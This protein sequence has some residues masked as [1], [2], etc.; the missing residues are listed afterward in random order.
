MLLLV[1]SISKADDYVWGEEFIEGDVISATTFN[2]IFN[3]L[4]KLNRTPVDADLVGT[5]SCS[6]LHTDF[7]SS[8]TTGWTTNNFVYTLTGAQ[9]TMTASTDSTSLVQPYSYS[10]SAPNPFYRH[11]TG[12]PSASGSY[13]LYEGILL[14]RMTVGIS[15]ST[16]EWKVDIISNDRFT[17][18]KMSTAANYSTYVICD[19][20]VAV[21]AAPTATAVTPSGTLMTVS[22]TDQSTD[23]TGFKIYRRLST[24]NEAKEIATAVTNSPYDDSGLTNGQT[25][26]YSVSAYN[27]NG[28]SAKS[29]IVS[30]TLDTIKPTIT[31]VFP[32]NG[33]T[34]ANKIQPINMYSASMIFSENVIIT[35][36]FLECKNLTMNADC[37]FVIS[38]PA[39]LTSPGWASTNASSVG[40]YTDPGLGDI[41]ITVKY[42]FIKDVSNNNLTED[43]IWS[44]TTQ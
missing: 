21:P 11:N 25:A 44:F 5:W 33:S 36:G 15:T 8:D 29:K 7:G 42:N 9:L 40:I 2:Q 37:N 43:Y 13:I 30:A 41:R 26:Y 18:E 10:T 38:S 12:N 16:T 35:E 28:E 3:T 27:D 20:A 1:T 14:L 17:L 34:T 19:S 23:E 4:Q 32:T 6:A 24:E 39:G 22:W 31:S